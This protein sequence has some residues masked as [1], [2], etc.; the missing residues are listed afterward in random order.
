MYELES[1]S[2]PGDIQSL[3][4]HGTLKVSTKE[5]NDRAE[6]LICL[7]VTVAMDK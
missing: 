1:N 2:L 6:N 4:V 5:R 3:E 7:N